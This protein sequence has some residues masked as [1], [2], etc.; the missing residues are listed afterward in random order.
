[1]SDIDIY[2]KSEN[3]VW[4][5]HW[6]ERRKRMVINRLSDMLNTNI[7]AYLDRDVRRP[8]WY[9]IAYAPSQL[10]AEKLAREIY[11]LRFRHRPGEHGNCCFHG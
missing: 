4:L 5:V 10:E 6:D 8:N 11:K 7:A 2:E 9:P 3:K 1:M